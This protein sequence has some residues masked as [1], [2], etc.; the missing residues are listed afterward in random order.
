V[1]ALLALAPGAASATSFTLDPNLSSLTLAADVSVLGGA[2]T[3][4][5]QCTGCLTTRYD[6]TLHAT[7]LGLAAVQFDGGGTADARQQLG[8]FNIPRQIAPG[9][10]GAAGTAPADYGVTFS[11]PVGTPLPPIDIPNVG[12]LNLGTLQSVDVKVALRDVVLD[13]TSTSFIPVSSGAFDASQANVLITANADVL[14]A[15]VLRAPDLATYLVNLS[16][17]TLLA[18][19]APQL[20]LTVSGNFLTRDISV[21]FGFGV[22]VNALSAPNTASGGLIS[23][24]GDVVTI[25]LPVDVTA[26]P[27]DITGVFGLDIGLQGSLRMVG[28]VPEPATSLLVGA[29]VVALGAARRR[30][31]TG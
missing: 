25:T 3:A 24:V 11:A 23:A 9:V 6:G 30:R 22:P 27:S 31:A 12:T 17:L 21:G 29:G 16:A 15:L 26:T 18:S 5:A 2:L 10:G 4:S 28:T 1:V 8:S 14:A 19:S 20:G 7:N 13:V